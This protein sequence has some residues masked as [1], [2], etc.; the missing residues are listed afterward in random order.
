MKSGVRSRPHHGSWRL[1]QEPQPHP[2]MTGRQG[3]TPTRPG[4]EA[5]KYP[6]TPRRDKGLQGDDTN[7]ST[8]RV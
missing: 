1:R 4:I 7:Q 3:S 6:P 2:V 8:R 5:I